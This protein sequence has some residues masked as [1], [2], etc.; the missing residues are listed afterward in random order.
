VH[1]V[2]VVA[3]HWHPVQGGRV[4]WS[5]LHVYGAHGSLD[6]HKLRLPTG[7]VSLAAVVRFPIEDLGVLPR[8]PARDAILER[9]ARAGSPPLA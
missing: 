1:D 9:H 5:H 7:T 2:P 3:F 6:L 8:R 4:T